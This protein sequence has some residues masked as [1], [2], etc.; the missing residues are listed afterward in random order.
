MTMNQKQRPIEYLPP[1][2]VASMSGPLIFKAAELDVFAHSHAFGGLI[3]ICY[4][5]GAQN[6]ASRL[7]SSVIRHIIPMPTAASSEE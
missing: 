5:L 6:L 2:I 3:I 4:M 7:W 1:W